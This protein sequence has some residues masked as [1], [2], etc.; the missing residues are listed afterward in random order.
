M[1]KELGVRRMVHSSS[2]CP[3]WVPLCSLLAGAMGKARVSFPPLPVEGEMLNE[4]KTNK[5]P[6]SRQGPW[7]SEW[8]GDLPKIQQLLLRGHET[9]CHCCSVVS[10]SLRPHGLQHNRLFCAP[11]SPRVCS[12]SCPLSRWCHPTI[13]S[14]GVPLLLCLQ[15][16]P[17][18]GS[19]PKSWTFPSGGQSIGASASASVFPMDIQ[20]WFPLGLTVLI[21]L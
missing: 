21:S 8:S 17:A 20:G 4:K 2:K 9:G 19:F 13:S 10:N 7:G 1:A 14:S 12:N 6:F 11:L 5:N 15:S 16:F 3:S 18:S